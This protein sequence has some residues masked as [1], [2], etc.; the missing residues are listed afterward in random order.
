MAIGT[1]GFDDQA[2]AAGHR[3]L[4][5]VPNVLRQEEHVAF[6]D[7]DVVELAVIVYLQ[8]HVAFELVEEL[9]DRVIV[10]VG[11]LVRPADHKGHHVGILPDL[12]VA[13]R[14]LQQVPV[15]FDPVLKIE[16]CEF[17]HLEPTP[18]IR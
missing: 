11:P 3:S 4:R 10:I 12:L 9:L 8:H 16:C 13:D 5:R 17:C 6:A 14:R 15:F 18:V 1:F 7:D 2:D